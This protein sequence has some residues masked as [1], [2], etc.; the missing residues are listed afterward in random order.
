M[1]LF[2]AQPYDPAPARRKRNTFL[3][4]IAL[5]ILI[6][7]VW[8]HFRLWPEERVVDRF[9]DALQQQNYEQAYGIWMHDPEWKQHPAEYSRYPYGEFVRDWGPGGEW[10][11]IK[12]HHI[13]GAAVPHGYSGSPFA[14][15]SGVVVVVTVNDRVADQARIW[16]Q[17]SDKTLGF[18]PY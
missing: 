6:G 13:D 9:F 14:R 5:V 8:W 10:G 12:S 17:K 7:L 1:T 15:A 18:S 11:I 16:V 3:A 2:E 4:L